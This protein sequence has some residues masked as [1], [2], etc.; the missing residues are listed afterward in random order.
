MRPLELACGLVLGFEAPEPWPPEGPDAAPLAAL[1]A[2]ILPALRHPP[3]LVSFSGGRD[4]SLVLAAATRLARRDG[5]PDPV[6]ATNRVADAGAAEETSWQEL[7]VAALGLPDWLRCHHTDELDAVGPYAQRLLRAHGLVWPF[8][9]HFHLPLIDAARGGS[10][11]TG[12]GGDE[13]FAAVQRSRLTAVRTLQVRPRRRDAGRA[14]LA[15]APATLRAGVLARRLPIDFP[16]LRAGAA[17]AALR[18]LAATSAREP[19][20]I[21]SRVPWYRALRYMR[22]SLSSLDAPARAGDVR[23]VHPLADRA[24]WCAIQRAAAP[25]GFEDRTAG[26]RRAFGDLLPPALLARGDKATFDEAFFTGQ[27]RAFANTWDGGGV[28][29]ALVDVESLRR[30]WQSGS[31]RAQSFSLLQAAWLSSAR[32]RAEQPVGRLR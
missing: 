32:D 16:W 10:L 19:H 25:H 8:N 24:L 31:P 6:P 26:M 17:R 7:L 21:G 2:A 27:A 18:E 9:A 23:I 28:P 5:L 15:L 1:E 13:L 22:L 11:L 14:A 3:C 12:I 4:S 30:H 29:E 20:G